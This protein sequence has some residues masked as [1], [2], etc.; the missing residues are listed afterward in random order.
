MY[1]LLATIPSF[2]PTILRFVLAVVFTVHGGQKTLGWF[3]GEG[4]RGTLAHWTAPA[5]DGLHFPYGLAVAGIVA[6]VIGAAGMCLGFLTRLAAL[7]LFCVMATAAVCVHG[8][9]GFF[10]PRG[11]E[12]PFSLAGVALALMCC[13][14]GRFSLDR[15]L[16]R[17]LL[18]PNGNPTMMGSYRLPSTLS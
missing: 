10:E 13:G 8:P 18:P 3:G 16:T 4:W 9:A 11:Y 12:Y 2:A 17:S 6:E 5:P 15:W 14:G 7:A 1:R